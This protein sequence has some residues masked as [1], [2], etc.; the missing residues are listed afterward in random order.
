[1][2]LVKDV[3]ETQAAIESGALSLTTASQLQRV[4]EIKQREKKSLDQREKLNLFHQIEDKSKREV[5][6]TLATLCPQSLI[7]KERDRYISEDKVQKTLVISERL[8]LKIERLKRLK[9]NKQKDFEVI[10]E[11]LVDREL[12][13]IDPMEVSP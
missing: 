4:F 9:S 3:P 1:M 2:Q 13:E 11:E 12:K 10:L 6:K 8:N 5:E 7:Q